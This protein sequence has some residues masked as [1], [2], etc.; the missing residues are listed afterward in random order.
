MFHP[1]LKS[2]PPAQ[3]ILWGELGTT[4]NDIVLHFME[5]LRSP[6]ASGIARH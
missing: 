6:F 3:Q 4:P 5:A 2:L 1:N